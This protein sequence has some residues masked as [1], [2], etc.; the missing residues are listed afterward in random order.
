MTAPPVPER[1]QQRY[2]VCHRRIPIGRWIDLT[3]LAVRDPDVLLDTLDPEAFQKEERLPYWAAIWPAAIGLGIHL[4][5][6]PMP[7]DTPVLELGCGIGVAGV[8]AATAGLMVHA[9]DYEP[10]ALAFAAY[11]AALNRVAH[12]MA[13][14]LLDWRTPDLNRQYPVVLGADIVYERPDHQPI[15]DLLRDTL[16]PGGTF[17]L[18]DPDRRPARDFVALMVRQ[19]YRHT[20]QPHRI[21]V[22]ETLH[23]ITVHRFLKPA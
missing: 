15:A 2:D 3:M 19:G 4:F 18:G 1:L 6:H 7:R 22:E 9:C 11:N 10:D 5:E 21:R 17:L 8:A 12:R 16:P 14:R 13:F 23:A 20:A